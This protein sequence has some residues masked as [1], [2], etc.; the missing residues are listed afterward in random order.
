MLEE[1]KRGSRGEA[2]GGGEG[3]GAGEADGEKM[4]D[5]DFDV[6]DSPQGAAPAGRTM[7]RAARPPAALYPPPPVTR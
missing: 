2:R 3:A 7:G 1:K 5:S 4:N 6:E